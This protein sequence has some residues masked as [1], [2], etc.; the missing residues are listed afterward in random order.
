MIRLLKTSIKENSF[1]ANTGKKD[2]CTE[3]Q[4]MSTDNLSEMKQAI[5]KCTEKKTII[6]EFI[7][8]EN[9][10]EKNRKIKIAS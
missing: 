4:R 9:I 7:F 10:L 5:G 1:K 3:E 2:T 6:R 8:H